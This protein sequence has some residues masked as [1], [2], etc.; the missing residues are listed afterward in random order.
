MLTLILAAFLTQVS[1]QTES[2]VYAEQ[3]KRI[4]SDPVVTATLKAIQ[5][6]HKV[7]CQLPTAENQVD[8]TCLKNSACL[9]RMRV[10][11]LPREAKT[12]HNYLEVLVTGFDN[13]ST[14]DIRSIVFTQKTK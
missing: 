7:A 5:I 9:Y 13:G 2:A 4:T 6:K 10:P 12:P 1:A 11:C 3:M 14:N 8:W